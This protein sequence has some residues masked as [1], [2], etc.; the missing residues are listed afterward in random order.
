M[1]KKNLD[2]IF[3]RK[4]YK[5]NFAH[6]KYNNKNFRYSLK[7]LFIIIINSFIFFS[8]AKQKKKPE[9]IKF[10]YFACFCAILR[11]E[12]LYIRD[13]IAYYLEIGFDKFIIGDNNYPNIEKIS[14]V[15]QDYIKSGILDIIEV[16]GTYFPLNEFFEMIYE[17]YKRKCAWISFFDG[18]EY[19]RM[20]SEDN[21]LISIKQYLS[22]PIFRK[23][24][25][26]SVNWL[27]YS[28][29]NLLH[30]DNKSVSERFTSPLYNHREN[31]LAKS[32]VRGNLNK[33]VFAKN[34]SSHIPNKK[35]HI[36]NSK[37]DIIKRYSA[38]Y[39]KPPLVKY[40]YLMHYTTKTVEEFI[41]KIKR[42]K[43]I[44]T[45]YD[46][47]ERIKKF[48]IINEYSQEKLKMFENAFN[49]TFPQFHNFK[50]Y[51]NRIYINEIFFLLSLLFIFF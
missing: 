48:F 8:Q 34:S 4:D 39:V 13:L 42:G 15:T 25:S 21:K 24:E 23:C 14:D 16:F 30:Y 22:N 41:Q 17:K 51:N 7:F 32:I 31:R 43:R 18:D 6:K 27:M 46:I 1:N 5:I 9:I 36:C 50:N 49:T 45:P 10:K 47:N 35:L 2:K 26:I 37:G 12:N 3:K 20:H 11:Q 19:L 38:I 44:N 40:T 29:N 33:I 28:D